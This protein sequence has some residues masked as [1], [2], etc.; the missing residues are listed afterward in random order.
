M[1]GVEEDL[2]GKYAAILK[3]RGPVARFRFNL[4][5]N[6][7]RK[8]TNIIQSSVRPNVILVQDF[9]S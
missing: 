7:R 4:A 5:T 6:E 3:I 1:T 2:S 9:C 8:P